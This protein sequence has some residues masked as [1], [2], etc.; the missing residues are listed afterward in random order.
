MTRGPRDL[1]PA[2]RG[3]WRWL[4]RNYDFTGAEPLAA[5]LC[6]LY[7]GVT[8]I[9]EKLGTPELKTADRLRL[10]NAE[11]KLAGAF[12]RAWRVLGLADDQGKAR[13]ARRAICGR[14]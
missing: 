14:G 11:V 2:G 6:R 1:R 7:D 5:E 8:D 12:L 4:V 9:R 13:I 10:I 3:L